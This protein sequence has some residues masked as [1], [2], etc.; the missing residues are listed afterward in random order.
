MSLWTEFVPHPKCQPMHDRKL[1]L[2]IST[3]CWFGQKRWMSTP[4]KLTL[5]VIQYFWVFYWIKLT[6]H[7]NFCLRAVSCTAACH[8]HDARSFT[9]SKHPQMFGLHWM[10]HTFL[11]PQFW[12]QLF[13]CLLFTSKSNVVCHYHPYRLNCIKLPFDPKVRDEFIS[14][15][16]GGIAL[17]FLKNVLLFYSTSI[18]PL[19]HFIN[20]MNTFFVS[21]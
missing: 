10:V 21:R 2:P 9:H 7:S 12:Y 6:T 13:F 16:Q 19:L 14:I 20:T 17:K 5:K 3:L 18:Y 11:C 8:F 1:F 4:E 15:Q